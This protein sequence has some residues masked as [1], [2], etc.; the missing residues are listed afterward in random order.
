MSEANNQPTFRLH[1]KID[2]KNQEKRI[3]KFFLGRTKHLEKILFGSELSEA[4][5]KPTFR[6]YQKVTKNREKRIKKLL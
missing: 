2:K 5:N 1:Q 6:L 4:N 3:E